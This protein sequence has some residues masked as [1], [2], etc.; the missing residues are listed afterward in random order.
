MRRLTTTFLRGLTA[1]LPA[2]LTL[3]L[4]YWLVTA[5]EGWLKRAFLLVFPE[6]TYFPGM[7]LAAGLLLILATGFLLEFFL[8]ERFWRWIEGRIEKIPLVKTI[9][10]ASRDFMGFFSSNT[11]GQASG[12]V[13]I[14]VGEH[15]GLIG[16][17]TDSGS[18]ALASI[19]SDHVAV[20]MPM[21]Y[22]IGGFTAMIPR[23]HLKKLDWSVEEAM[24][25]VLTA[26]IQKKS[27]AKPQSAPEP[28]E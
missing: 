13:F 1:L 11:S 26:G 9:F 27:G 4:V 16:F 12:V 19:G 24:R 6:S 15:A 8:I 17:V 7:G 14:Q 23:D 5:T 28:S 3:W 22:Q 18:R 2:V 25:Y 20:Y 21:S 10:D